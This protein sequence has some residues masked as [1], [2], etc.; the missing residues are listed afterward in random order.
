VA[1]QFRFGTERFA[2]R[3][4]SFFGTKGGCM[5]KKQLLEDIKA[6]PARF[7]RAPN[8]VMRDRR[9]SDTERLEI[10]QAWERDA[11]ALVVAGHESANGAEPSWLKTIVAARLEVEK[12]LP[13]EV[14]YPESGK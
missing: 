4:R 3:K 2:A 9:F 14:G 5:T 8:D 7:F 10:L 6:D 13:A 12:K 11:R 1:P